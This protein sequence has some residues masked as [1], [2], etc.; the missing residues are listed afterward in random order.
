MDTFHFLSP[1]E[2]KG[3]IDAST[4]IHR[5]DFE[6]VVGVLTG[7]AL[8]C[9]IARIAIR[10]I[11]QK[12]LRVDDAFLI[13]AVA[14]LC[15]A[16]GILYH[17]SYFLY[18]HSAALFVPGILPYL[19]ADF[20]EL[21]KFQKK[22][23]PYLTLIWTTTFAVKACFLTFMRPLIWHVSRKMNWY[24]WFIV[25][26]TAVTW[27][28]VV[29]EP[30]I[31]CPYFELEAVKCFSSTVASKK[32]IGLTALV[33]TL[34]ILSDIMI[35]SLPI[36]VLKGSQLSKST[37]AGLAMFLCLSIVMAIFAIIRVAGFHY[38]GKEDD[39]WAFFW[40]HAEG[41][42]AVMMASIT[43][44]RT[45]FVK[46][47]D[48]PDVTTPRSPVDK[49]VQRISRRFQAL[50]RAAPD[51]KS[52][53]STPKNFKVKLPKLPAPTLTGIRTFIHRNNRTEMSSVSFA[54]LHSDLDP[55]EAD[56]HAA[57]KDSRAASRRTDSRG[58]QQS[59]V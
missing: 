21:L 49:L 42:V 44:F 28:F 43:A 10:L 8:C 40:Q 37:K 30:F 31:I 5:R 1:G 54:T 55:S 35:V 27:A 3:R 4:Q 53:P 7:L 52:I 19:L 57:L 25:V 50:A 9:F 2:V 16:T 32:T 23:Y 36:I 58:E 12:T 33:T 47:T 11:Y 26:F 45:L 38:H 14:C 22:V 46:P 17:I 6:I 59:F 51:E 48:D 39:T 15:A 24:F 29:V 34:D 41:A 18:M 20:F 13:L 56:Y